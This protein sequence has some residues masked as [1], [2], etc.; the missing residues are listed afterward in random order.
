[1]HNILFCLSLVNKFK[2]SAEFGS[3][4]LSTYFASISS[5][6]LGD[7]SVAHKTFDCPAE[8]SGHKAVQQRVDR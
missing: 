8:I 6:R 4:R 2:I 7:S 3:R 5:S 1:M